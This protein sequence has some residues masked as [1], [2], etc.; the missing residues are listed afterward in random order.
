MFL[1]LK[2]E[3]Y[4]YKRPCLHKFPVFASMCLTG[5]ILCVGL[6]VFFGNV[7]VRCEFNWLRCSVFLLK[8][9]T[10]MGCVSESRL[11][12]CLQRQRGRQSNVTKCRPNSLQRLGSPVST[13]PDGCSLHNIGFVVNQIFL[14]C[15]KSAAAAALNW[16]IPGSRNPPTT[17]LPPVRSPLAQYLRVDNLLQMAALSF[18][19]FLMQSPASLLLSTSIH[20]L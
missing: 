1:I 19:I 14:N 6:C 17:D 20:H 9:H 12:K 5:F 11:G 10:T 16:P 8:A 7:C 15:W 2:M 4:K 18:P 3:N 13:S